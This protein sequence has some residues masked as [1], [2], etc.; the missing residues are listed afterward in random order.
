MFLQ[1]NTSTMKTKSTLLMAGLIALTTWGLA[2]CQ[3]SN[4]TADNSTSPASTTGNA[5]QALNGKK[6]FTVVPA[7]GGGDS[8]ITGTNGGAT[9]TVMQVIR[10]DF[11]SRGYV[12]QENGPA[13]L[14]VTPK[15]IYSGSD[16]QQ[17]TQVPGAPSAI[18]PT[19]REVTLNIII[20]DTATDKVLWS[21]ENPSAVLTPYLSSDVATT[22]VHQALR[23]LPLAN[24]GAP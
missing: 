21:G 14:T 8:A 20:K 7:M 11:E 15:W 17:P 16:A 3:S 18:S 10:P 24:S 22:M 1:K 13:D 5:T 2:G 4:T 6:T 12:Y 23:D 9:Q 19:T